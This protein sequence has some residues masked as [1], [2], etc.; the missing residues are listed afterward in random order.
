M[1]G[2]DGSAFVRSFARAKVNLYLHV[3]GRRAD[4]YH[5]LDSLV[6]FPDIGDILRV[7]KARSLSLVV[8]GPF[9]AGVPTDS[10]NSL[11]RA[12]T[13]LIEEAKVSA[14][15]EIRLTK[16]LPVAAGIG[17][18]SA[19]AAAAVRALSSIWDLDLPSER[20]AALTLE[21]GADVP[22]CLA[23]RPAFA[24]GIGELLEP[25]PALPAFALLLANPGAELATAAVFRAFGTSSS[26]AS[27]SQPGR[28]AEAPADPL[29]LARTLA[30]HRNDLTAAAIA[31]C[32]AAAEVLAAL[33]D[34]EDALLVRMSGSGATCFAL[35][36][37]S[38]AAERGAARLRQ[39]HPG[40]WVA[41]AA[42]AGDRITD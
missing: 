12:A 36:A 21:L 25:A 24:G 15:A 8:D 35:F 1:I 18:G 29:D 39:R 4:G 37:E 13:R 5:L 41:P 32:P 10:S 30:R 23:S 22:M 20:L 6:V 27:F 9:A 14:G 33:A 26:H 7:R 40:W 31:L 38:S 42:V 34:L 28:F 3:T 19:D 2:V 16:Q 11:M 17:G